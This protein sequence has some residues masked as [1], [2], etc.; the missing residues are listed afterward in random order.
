[1]NPAPTSLQEFVDNL[2]SLKPDFYFQRMNSEKYKICLNNKYH[3]LFLWSSFGSAVSLAKAEFDN[4][5][6]NN[7]EPVIKIGPSFSYRA[8]QSLVLIFTFPAFI[9]FLMN[10]DFL[11]M[12]FP[13]FVCGLFFVF[14]YW[15]YK[16]GEGLLIG[17]IQDSIE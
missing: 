3:N 16:F 12:F 14:I 15:F 9:I 6:I 13:L 11:L 8:F 7:A 5:V 10:G 4:S 1:M 2:E 17:K